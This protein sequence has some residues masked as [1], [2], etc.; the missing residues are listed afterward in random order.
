MIEKQFITAQELLEDSFR[1]GGKILKSG[2]RPNFIVGIWRGGTPVGIAV[3]EVL[4]YFGIRHD[5][6]GRSA[7]QKFRH[8]SPP[9]SW[10]ETPDARSNARRVLRAPIDQA[11]IRLILASK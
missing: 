6:L 2:F 1:L 4:D 11:A 10:W 7:D 8:G 9:A 5:A 3:Q